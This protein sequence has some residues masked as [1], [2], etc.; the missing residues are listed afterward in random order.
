MYQHQEI[1]K[2]FV[3]SSP[4]IQAEFQHKQWWNWVF[5]QVQIIASQ[6]ELHTY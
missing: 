1:K 3:Y 4:S 6:E 5:N 2:F